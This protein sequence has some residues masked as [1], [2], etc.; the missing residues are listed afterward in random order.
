MSKTIKIIISLLVIMILGFLIHQGNAPTTNKANTISI[1]GETCIASNGEW[2]EEFQ[3][4]TGIDQ[5]SCVALGGEFNECASACRNDTAAEICTMQCVQV[6]TLK[7]M[8]TQ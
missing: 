4:C 1:A 6:C 5:N 7:T 3:E 2:S 8:N